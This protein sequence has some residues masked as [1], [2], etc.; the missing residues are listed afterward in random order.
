MTNG[1]CFESFE[2]LSEIISPMLTR[3]IVNLYVWIIEIFLWFAVVV[4]GIAGYLYTVPLLKSAGG[5][6]QNDVAGRIAGALVF[7]LLSFIA[8]AVIVGPILVLIDIRKS[9]RVIEA[10]HAGSL[11]EALPLEQREPFL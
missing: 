2:S 5:V 6:L 8:L 1:L 9:L 11:S 10:K 7:S 4:F 3:L